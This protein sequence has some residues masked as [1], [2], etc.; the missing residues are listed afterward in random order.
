MLWKYQDD[1]ATME[2]S[3][4][5]GSA[6]RQMYWYQQL[7]VQNM[8]QIVLTTAYS[9][10]E[11]EQGFNKEKFPAQKKDA[12][13]GSLTVNKLQPEDSGVY[14][15]AVNVSLSKDVHQDPPS[16]LGN[17]QS[18]ATINCNHSI[19]GYYTILWYQKRI[20]DSALKLI[21]YVYYTSVTLEDEFK[22]HFRV[23]GD[24]SKESELQVQ[25]LQ[26]EDSS[27]YYCAASLTDGSDV[28]QTPLL[29]TIES[30]SA[31]MSCSHT[32]DD[33]HNQMYWYQQLPGQNMKLIVFTTTYSAH[34]YEKDFSLTDGNDV[35]Q[36]PLLWTNESQSATMSCSHTK[37]T[38]YDQ[39]YWYQQLP[40]QNMKL[41]VFTTAYSAHQYEKGFSLTNGS[42][43]TQTPLLWM[44]QGQSG[45]MNC[46]HTKDATYFQMYWYQQLPGQNMKLIVFTTSSPPY[47]YEKGFSEEKFPAEKKNAQTGSL[48]VK[49]LQPEDSGVY[50]CAV[51]QHSD[52][53]D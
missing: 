10:H 28:T 29:W 15:C 7:P 20:G 30:Q 46:S 45:T 53:S 47:Q 4:T 44:F 35:T 17:P 34:Q 22:D 14:F 12:E 13:T 52:A 49:K 16:I 18:P 33:N 43:V 3:H 50:F 24:G 31:T 32:K 48:T 23:S 25:K 1:N 19:S 41:I 40:G 37:G 39:M 9:P 26:P 27:S 36:T 11:Y 38:S 51:S 21:G 2:C 5:K 42:D 8:K 6:Y